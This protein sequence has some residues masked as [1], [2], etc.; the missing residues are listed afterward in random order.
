MAADE[1]I[2]NP[3]SLESTSQQ[4]AAAAPKIVGV[5][6]SGIEDE[7]EMKDMFSADFQVPSAGQNSRKQE[8]EVV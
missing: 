7:E 4:H 5:V 3:I 1:D 6:M 2:R 8:L